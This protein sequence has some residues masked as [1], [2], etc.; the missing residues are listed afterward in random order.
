MR[1]GGAARRMI[2]SLLSDEGGA[3]AVENLCIIRAR[4]LKDFRK[5]VC[6]HGIQAHVCDN[7]FFVLGIE[8]HTAGLL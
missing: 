5:V 2:S 3:A 6:E 7:N 1:V 4:L 8:G